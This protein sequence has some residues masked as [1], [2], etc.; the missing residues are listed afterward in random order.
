[1]KILQR[2]SKQTTSSATAISG[3]ISGYQQ[4][5]ASRWQALP[6]RD[7]MALGL[8]MLFLA[9]FVGGYGGYSLNQMAQQSKI[10]YHSQVADYF[11]LRAQSA[12]IDNQALTAQVGGVDMPPASKVETV[13]NASGINDAQVI[14]AGE[15][16]QFSF[17]HASQGIV[18]NVLGQLEQ[19]GWQFSQLSLQ[20]DISTKQIQVQATI[21]L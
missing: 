15:S 5:M 7:R 1:M 10:S 16:V 20:Q 6:S 18:S 8:L 14:A 9:V 19:Q 4:K 12:N 11:W 21:A 13:L 17:S 3:R 2:R